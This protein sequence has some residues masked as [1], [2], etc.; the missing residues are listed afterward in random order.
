MA[1]NMQ[2]VKERFTKHITL[3]Y[4]LIQLKLCR[5]A[6]EWPMWKLSESGLQVA[7]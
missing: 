5:I 3:K 2:C 6:G 1:V 7:N 4:F